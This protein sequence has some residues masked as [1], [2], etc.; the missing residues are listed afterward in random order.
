MK[1]NPKS[2]IRNPKQARDPNTETARLSPRAAL[3]LPIPSVARKAA[4]DLLLLGFAIC[5]E[6]RAAVLTFPDASGEMALKNQDIAALQ[7]EVAGDTLKVTVVY[8]QALGLLDINFGDVFIDGDRD[9]DTGVRLGADCIVEFIL[10]GNIPIGFLKLSDRAVKLGAEGTSAQA[11]TNCISFLLP[12]S[13][14]GG[15]PNVRLF[16]TSA[17]T[18]ESTLYDRVPDAG[19][20][21]KGSVL[22]IDTLALF[23]QSSVH[24]AQVESGI[25]RSGL[26]GDESR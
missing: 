6:S 22:A 25:A 14:W 23:P 7:T 13:L 5:L 10:A 9:P 1:A 21:V 12:L 19:W 17:W 3:Q 16:A 2:E 24:G 20:L 11:G 8:G 4:I 18:L 26:P 15:N